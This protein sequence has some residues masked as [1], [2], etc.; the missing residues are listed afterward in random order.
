M[1]LKL[2]D[3]NTFRNFIVNM[4]GDFHGDFDRVASHIQKKYIDAIVAQ[5][6]SYNKD[7]CLQE[8]VPLFNSIG[9]GVY[10]SSKEQSGEIKW[11]YVSVGDDGTIDYSDCYNK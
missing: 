10:Y 4:L 5:M 3:A 1:A 8:I 11:K 6:Q 2:N 7:I 9:L